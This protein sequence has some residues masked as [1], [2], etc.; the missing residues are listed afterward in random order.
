M[1]SLLKLTFP[2]KQIPA[3]IL[4]VK[5]GKIIAKWEHIGEEQ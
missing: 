4:I 3:Y 5:Q 1:P 2:I